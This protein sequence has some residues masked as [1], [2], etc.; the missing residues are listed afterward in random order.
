MRSGIGLVVASVIG[1]GVLTTTGFLA[2]GLGPRALLAAWFVGGLIAIAGALAY[3]SL[4]E[5]IPGAGGEYRYLAALIH[6]AMGWWAGWT[7]MFVGFA[8]P[9]AMAATAAGAWI[10]VLAPVNPTIAGLVVLGLMTALHAVNAAL[11]RRTQNVLAFAK[12]ALLV[13]FGGLAFVKGSHDLPT[14]IVP[15]APNAGGFGSFSAALVVVGFCYSGWNAPVYVADEFRMP[16]R[17]VA[18]AMV[19][20]C[21]LVVLLYMAVNLVLVSNL[22]SQDLD[23]VAK[24][25]DRITLAHLVALRLAGPLAARAVSVVMVIVIV[26]SLSAMT[27]VGPRVYTAMAADGMLPKWL[28]TRSSGAPVRAVALQ[29]GIAALLMLVYNFRTLLDGAGALLTLASIMAVGALIVRGSLRGLGRW[30]A[31]VFVASS[32]WALA[33]SIARAPTSLI[34]MGI[35]TVTAAMTW[36]LRGGKSA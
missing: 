6:P 20:G 18:R 25:A 30:A 21:A 26:S 28:S 9:M 1:S 11:S 27:V 13:A 34:W 12:F 36:P 29:S 14:A 8:A 2:D 32:G 35:V 23:A 24:D 33:W 7:S 15:L 19:I 16:K 3:G 5:A 10:A 31:C 17:D 4:A 22:R